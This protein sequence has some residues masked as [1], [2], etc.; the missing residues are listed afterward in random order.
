[1]TVEGADDDVARAEALKGAGNELF[2]QGHFKEAVDKYNDAIELNPEAPI[3]P[4]TPQPLR[5][6]AH[7]GAASPACAR[8]LL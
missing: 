1:M 8:A 2:Q 4:C 3:I 6:R 5:R 7:A